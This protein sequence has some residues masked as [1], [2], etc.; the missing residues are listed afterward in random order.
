M[1]VHVRFPLNKPITLP[2]SW[3]LE[4]HDVIL[5]FECEDGEADAILVTFKDQPVNLSPAIT[6]T[7]LAREKANIEIRGD[8]ETKAAEIVRRLSD[9]I[10]LYQSLD[11]RLDDVE[12]S[13]IGKTAQE[14]EQ[15]HVTKFNISKTQPRRRFAFSMLAQSFFAGEGGDDPSFVSHMAQLAREALITHK[16]IDAFRYAFLLCEAL[17]GNG[18]FKTVQL[19]QALRENV[20]F[21]SIVENTISDFKTNPIHK[22]SDVQLLIIKY[23]TA[24]EMIEHLVAQRG[25]YF[26]GNLSRKDAW[27]PDHQQGAKGIAE[28]AVYGLVGGIA[29]SFSDQMFTP[30]IASRYFKNAQKQGAI[31]AIK[32][33]IRFRDQAGFDRQHILKLNT[34][35][36]RATN[37][38]ALD[39]HAEFLNWAKV[40]LNDSILISAIATDEKTGKELFRSQ[41]LDPSTEPLGSTS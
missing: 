2:D 21:H 34:P 16:Y 31:M 17:Y 18:K 15:I 29:H 27:H 28:V 20:Q 1:D 37:S 39:V 38:M 24:A 26:H 33:E 9:Y 40:E 6:Q 35:G 11:V 36:T 25:F 32:V 22:G 12:I 4:G 14:R 41:Y 3:P 8:Y 23:P 7:P 19:V 5:E 13:Y 30:E 10:G